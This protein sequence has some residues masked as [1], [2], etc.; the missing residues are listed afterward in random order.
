LPFCELVAVSGQENAFGGEMPRMLD[1]VAVVDVAGLCRVQFDGSSAAEP[2][3][4]CQGRS[5]SG[6]VWRSKRE[7]LGSLRRCH[8]VLKSRN[9]VDRRHFLHSKL[10][11]L[12]VACIQSRTD[13]VASKGYRCRCAFQCRTNFHPNF[14]RSLSTVFRDFSAGQLQ[15]NPGQRLIPKGRNS[16]I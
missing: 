1:G 11:I 12:R 2:D 3:R 15:S 10:G 7:P 8:A 16:G 6:P 13:I 5:K 14:V 9:L 4:E